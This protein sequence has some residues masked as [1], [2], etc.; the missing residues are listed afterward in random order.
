MRK[1]KIIQHYSLDG[2]VQA[3]GGPEEDPSGG[4]DHGGWALRRPD[5]AIG[6]AI[7]G[8]HGDRFDLLLG[9]RT[10]DIWS[11]YW[12]GQSGPM[13]D[14]LNSATKFVATHRPETLHWGPA[15][16]LGPDVYAG[17]RAMKATAG[18]DVVLWGSSTLTSRLLADALADEL[19]LLI[20]PVLLGSGKRLFAAA[21]PCDLSLIDAKPTGAGALICHFAVAGAP[22]GL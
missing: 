7:A 6:E 8:A 9:R 17:V 11:D 12:P 18:P 3:P 4:F 14:Q 22:S 1:I 13:A 10:Y 21:P 15:Q 16:D 20:R 2:V 19:L 5:P